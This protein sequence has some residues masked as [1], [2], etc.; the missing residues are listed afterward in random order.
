MTRRKGSTIEKTPNVIYQ[1]NQGRPLSRHEIELRQVLQ[2]KG[3][4]AGRK[5]VAAARTQIKRQIRFALEAS[6]NPK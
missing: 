6:K 1:R 4:E 3:E 5:S 2:R